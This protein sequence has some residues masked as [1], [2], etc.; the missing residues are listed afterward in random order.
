M[1]IIYIRTSTDE[2]NPIYNTKR[3]EKYINSV[4]LLRYT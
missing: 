4:Y 2:Q 3:L 1:K